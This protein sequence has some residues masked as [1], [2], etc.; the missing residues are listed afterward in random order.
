MA[1]TPLPTSEGVLGIDRTT[2]PRSEGGLEAGRR[3]AGH[4]REDPGD[5]DGGQG[6]QDRLGH[7]GLHGQ[8]GA[9]GG[10]RGVHH[11][12]AGMGLGQPLALDRVGIA[13]RQV[14]RPG[15]QPA[16]IRP[17]SRAE[18]IFPPPTTSSFGVMG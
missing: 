5:P 7:V 2:T 14:A 13:H 15:A 16:A 12:Q 11:R 10:D 17:V 4:D 6:A 9:V 3:E 8:Q 18:P 1:A